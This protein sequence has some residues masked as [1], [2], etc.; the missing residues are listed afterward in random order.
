MPGLRR[1]DDRTFVGAFQGLDRAIINPW[2]ML[3]FFGALVLSGA[4]ALLNL[5]TGFAW[6]AAAFA[7]YLVTIVIT[8][9]IHVPVNDALKAA[10]DP[11]GIADLAAVR[12]Q[13]NEARWATWNVVRTVTAAISFVLLVIATLRRQG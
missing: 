7:L 12:Q 9:A 11:G 10:G 3:C 4:A 1:T 8:L 5:H 2:F 13:F 6:L